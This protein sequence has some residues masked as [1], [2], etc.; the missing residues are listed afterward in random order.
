MN[1]RIAR[2][3]RKASNYVVEDAPKYGVI[4]HNMMR[5]FKKYGKI[6]AVPI[7]KHSRTNLSKQKYSNMKKMYYNKQ[8]PSYVLRG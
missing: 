2:K 8:L 7:Q 1:G 3:L 4:I 5:Y 6:E